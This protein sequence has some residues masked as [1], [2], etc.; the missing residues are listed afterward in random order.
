MGKR[1]ESEHTLI[2]RGAGDI[3]DFLKDYTNFSRLIPEQVKNWEATPDHCSFEIQGM[4]SLGMRI[5]ERIPHEKI[6]MTG[7]GKLP[8]SF[9]LTSHLE[10]VSEQSTMVR[11]VIDSD[12]N[13][14]MA[15]MVEKPLSNFINLLVFQL[16]KVMES[17]S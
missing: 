2:E 1:I 12:L 10:K 17:G 13:T 15:M 11:L 14:F 16:K 9:T 7:E 5:T 4:A 6:V 8:F 3:Y